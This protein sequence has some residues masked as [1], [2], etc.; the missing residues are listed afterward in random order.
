MTK[1]VR[2]DKKQKPMLC[3]LNMI[4]SIGKKKKIHLIKCKILLG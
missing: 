1:I 2:W 3:H 4:M